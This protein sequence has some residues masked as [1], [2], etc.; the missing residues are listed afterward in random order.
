MSR[1]VERVS[2]CPRILDL[3]RSLSVQVKAPKGSNEGGSEGRSC[4]AEARP[5]FPD[6]RIQV[7]DI[8]LGNRDAKQP[9]VISHSPKTGATLYATSAISFNGR[10]L[11]GLRPLSVSRKGG[12]SVCLNVP[13]TSPRPRPKPQCAG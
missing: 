10:S 5:T 6:V 13:R 8:I 7:E 12:V 3:V 1:K 2:E 11:T 4:C 9:L